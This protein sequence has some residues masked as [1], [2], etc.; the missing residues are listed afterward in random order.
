MTVPQLR[1]A[2]EE[3][4]PIKIKSI[5]FGTELEYKRAICI[6]PMNDGDEVPRVV[7]EDKN[8]RSVVYC[9]ITQI[10]GGDKYEPEEETMPEAAC[11]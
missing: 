3:Q 1:E 8:G 2:I 9:K 10:I 4:T 7:L 6:L 11:E 5:P